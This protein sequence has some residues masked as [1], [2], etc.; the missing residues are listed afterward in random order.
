MHSFVAVNEN[1]LSSSALSLPVAFDHCMEQV[2][3]KLKFFA[4]SV[5]CYWRDLDW[6]DGHRLGFVL[7]IDQN[8]GQSVQQ[9]LRCFRYLWFWGWQSRVPRDVVV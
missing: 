5:K 4:F 7:Q 3:K 9:V 1:G 8:V 2:L 6:S